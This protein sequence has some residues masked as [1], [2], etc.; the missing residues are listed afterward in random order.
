MANKT[1]F[2]QVSALSAVLAII[3]SYEGEFIL[4][5]G[6]QYNKAELAEKIDGM[7]E[8]L[9]AKHSTPSKADKA[10]AEADEVLNGII[11]MVLDEAESPICI[12]DMQKQSEELAALSNQ[13]MSAL[14]KKMVDSGAVTKTIQKKKAYFSLTVEE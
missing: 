13:K 4:V 6:E 3:D 11:R 1:S 2:T 14:L 12:A 7:R 8:K 5:G 9:A 10:K